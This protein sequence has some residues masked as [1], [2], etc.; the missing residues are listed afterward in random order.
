MTDRRSFIAVLALAPVAL[1]SSAAASPVDQFSVALK[2]YYAKRAEFDLACSTRSSDDVT[3][4]AC[5]AADEAY[6][7]L[8]CLPSRNA[9]DIAL[10]LEITLAEYEDC[11]I[12]EERLRS[13]AQD[14]R[15]LAA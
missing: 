14:A 4:A 2:T 8:L 9:A 7:R 10:K 3:N 11:E 12:S 15:R 6:R 13:I 1:A 5:R